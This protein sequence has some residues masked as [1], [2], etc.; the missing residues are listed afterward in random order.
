MKRIRCEWPGEDEDEERGSSPVPL[1]KVGP[2][3]QGR[4]GGRK[5][6]PTAKV[7]PAGSQ[8][9]VDDSTVDVVDPSDVGE[10]LLAGVGTSM[11]KGSVILVQR[12]PSV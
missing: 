6:R 2:P 12:S 8:V 5:K 7:A 9:T 1:S 10:G 11:S 3:T 4:R